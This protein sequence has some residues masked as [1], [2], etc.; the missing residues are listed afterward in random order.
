MRRRGSPPTSSALPLSPPARGESFRGAVGSP[1]LR[2]SRGGGAQPGGA[3]RC[4]LCT[5]LPTY[6][7]DWPLLICAPCSPQIKYTGFRDR[8]HEE[9][10][11]RFQNACRDGRSEIVSGSALPSGPAGTGPGACQQRAGERPLPGPC[12]ASLRFLL[13]KKF[14]GV[15]EEEGRFG[16]AELRGFALGVAGAEGVRPVPAVGR[17]WVAAPRWEVFCFR[18]KITSA[19]LRTPRLSLKGSIYFPFRIALSR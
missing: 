10:Q 12:A 9:R 14:Q 3:G 13:N 17:G 11:A 8:P 16:V 15:F 2:L 5:P 4:S 18:E 7:R 1:A 19:A 6:R